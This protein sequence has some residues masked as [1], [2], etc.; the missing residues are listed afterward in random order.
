MCCG[1]T[2][3][4]SVG[5]PS[6]EGVSMPLRQLKFKAG[7]QLFNSKQAAVEYVAANGGT[8]ERVVIETDMMVQDQPAAP[9]ETEEVL[10]SS[11]ESADE[12][13]KTRKSGS[14]RARKS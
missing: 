3:P 9:V 6:G 11:T 8:W 2:P 5:S 4:A 10:V 1:K 13:A 7:D 12:E 14:S